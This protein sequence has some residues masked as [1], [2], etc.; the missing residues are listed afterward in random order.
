MAQLALWDKSGTRRVLVDQQ[1]ENFAVIRSR[2]LTEYAKVFALKALPIEFRNSSPLLLESFVFGSVAAFCS[3][4]SWSTY[5]QGQAGLS[6]ILLCFAVASLLSLLNLYPR[7]AGPSEL[8]GDRIVLRTLF[9]TENIYKKSVSGVEL[10]DVA[11]PRSGTKFSFVILKIT[12]GKPLRIT[13]KFGSIPE[14]YL[15]LRAWL[16]QSSA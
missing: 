11:N 3:W 2:I 12:D 5:Q 10:A 6:V 4:G 16:A 14:I 7:I 13:S 8:F 1:F 9:K 15:T